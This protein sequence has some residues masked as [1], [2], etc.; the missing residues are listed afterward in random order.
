M[1]LKAHY[2]EAGIG[3][4][5]DAVR[6]SACEGSFHLASVGLGSNIGD[7]EAMI[8]GAI[9]WL[10]AE[11]GNSVKACSSLYE[12]EPYGKKDQDWFLNCVVQIQT[13]QGL[14]GFFRKLKGAEARFGR[15]RQ[16]PWGPR[17]LDLGLLFFDDV[18]FS[19]PELTVP[20]PGIPHRRFVLEPLVEIAP[21]LRHPALGQ[22][23]RRLLEVLNDPG[24]VIRLEKRPV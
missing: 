22:T 16:E 10:A 19:D 15:V 8:R 21:E 24:R 2:F 7:R 23:V 18:I 11:P 12:T 9:Q 1:C 4:K 14:N 3:R 13:S 20:H 17:T 6:G 5:R